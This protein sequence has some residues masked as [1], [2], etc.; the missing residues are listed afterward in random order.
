MN[1]APALRRLELAPAAT[2]ATAGLLL[3]V[4]TL[5]A[6]R[7]HLPALV[8]GGP[9]T[10]DAHTAALL[11]LLAVEALVLWRAAGSL[12]RQVAAQRRLRRLPV[13]AWRTVGPHTVA[14]VAGTRAGAFCAGLLRP[15]VY[16]TE[17]A[18]ARLAPDELRAV[19]EHETCHA[20]RRDPLRLAVARVA[21]DAL[22]FIPLLHRLTRSQA[23]VADLTA[24]RAAVAAVGSAQPLAAAL[25]RLDE[26]APERVDHLLGR[27]LPAA[28]RSLFACAL[29]ML[30]GLAALA[31]LLAVAPTDPALPLVLLPGLAVPALLAFRAARA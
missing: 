6:V 21:A 22:G 29:A 28:P 5:D 13:L 14:V 2:I 31:V 26:P 20:R 15:R 30:A 10:L 4:V 18:V 7:F 25:L 16:V 3:L 9:V 17:P 27:P 24:D 12:L 1:G 8:T 11:A 23:A 19:V